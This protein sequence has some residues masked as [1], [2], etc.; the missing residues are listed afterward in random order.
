MY[1]NN[2]VKA[3]S[4]S[5]RLLKWEKYNRTFNS[6]YLETRFTRGN[7]DLVLLYLSSN[8]KCVLL[9]LQQDHFLKSDEDSHYCLCNLK[10]IPD[11]ISVT[12]VGTVAAEIEYH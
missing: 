4:D 5:Q 7:E 9:Y 6:I 10:C 8:T 12:L 1:F 3:L 11:L 2:L